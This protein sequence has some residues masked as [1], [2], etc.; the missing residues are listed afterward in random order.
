M[1]IKWPWRKRASDELAKLLGDSRN[2][3]MFLGVKDPIIPTQ[4]DIRRD[5]AK[6]VRYSTTADYKVFADEVF[7][8]VLAHLDVMMDERATKERVDYHRGAA[9]EALDLLR[10][11]YQAKSSMQAYDREQSASTQR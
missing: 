9:K 6:L 2:V 1:V 3:E 8:R 5:A 10:L 11:S 4:E 7:S